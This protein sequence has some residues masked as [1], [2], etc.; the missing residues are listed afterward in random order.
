MNHAEPAGTDLARAA[1][2]AAQKAARQ[3]GADGNAVQKP[4]PPRRT[5]RRDGREPMD[6]NAA[7][8]WMM[9]EHGWQPRIAGGTVLDRWPD[10][11]PPKVAAHV[12]AVM[13]DDETGRLELLPDSDAWALQVR[14]SAAKLMQAVNED[15]G[16]RTVREIRVLRVGTRTRTPPGTDHTDLPDA[17][18]P[19]PE[20]TRENASRGYHR[21][22][23]ALRTARDTAAPP[24][25]VHPVPT[26]Q[27][28]SLAYHHAL[29]ALQAEAAPRPPAAPVRTRDDA[30]PHYHQAL[31]AL[32][33]SR[34][35]EAPSGN[36]RTR[37][38]A[39]A[40]Y[41]LALR[42]HLDNKGALFQ[43]ER[44]IRTP[45]PYETEPSR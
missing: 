32:H 19:G 44:H 13:F 23:D 37:E 20:R 6:F 10:I 31:N 3:R 24:G 35:D 41:R 18:A 8:T 12:E 17:P 25:P 15:A 42:A 1:L 16:R 7:L 14:L 30:P 38:D 45:A 9:T 11:A 21:A 2:R 27:D 29:N 22:L 40:G 43:P 36:P 28:A 4:K 34:T 39:S 33:A 26:R 5:V